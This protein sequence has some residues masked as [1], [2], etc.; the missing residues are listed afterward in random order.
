M[1]T[2]SATPGSLRRNVLGTVVY[3]RLDTRPPS[4]SKIIL[5]TS[6]STLLYAREVIVAI[7]SR[8]EGRPIF[9]AISLQFISE[10]HKLS[11]HIGVALWRTKSSAEKIN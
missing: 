7:G 5:T 6:T 4:F 11:V 3:L 8:F 9:N 1:L 10:G 2:T